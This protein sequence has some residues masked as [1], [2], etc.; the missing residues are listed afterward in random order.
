M[1]DNIAADPSWWPHRYD[2]T[3]DQV[4]YIRATR[5]DHRD[6]VF[7]TDEY[8]KNASS[9]KAVALGSA[10]VASEKAP[11]HFVFH[12]AYCCSTLLARAFDLPGSSMGLKEPQIL[13]DLFGW[14]LRGARPEDIARTMDGVLA[15]LSKPFKPGEALVVKPSNVVNGLAGLMLHLRPNSKA[16]FLYAPLRDFLGS[17]ARKEMWGRHWV[18]DLMVKQ[19]R[20]GMINLGLQGDDYLQLTD[21]QVAAVGWLAQHMLFLQIIQKYGETRVK[22]LDSVTLMCSPKEAM[23]NLV[24]HYDLP[25]GEAEVDTLV[26]GPVFNK[27]AKTDKEFDASARE[28]DRKAGDQLHADEIEKVTLWAEAIAKNV[29]VPMQLPASL[30]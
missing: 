4:H 21:L 25:I 8:L 2:S 22:T 3:R 15:V 27:H 24:A 9:P 30:I 10:A 12:S 14:R 7:L 16:L 1:N 17:I 23:Q 18:R 6:A 29:G 5:D 20:S 26:D 19:L 11:V 13:N 28:A